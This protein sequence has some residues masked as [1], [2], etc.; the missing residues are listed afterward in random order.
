MSQITNPITKSPL[1]PINDNEEKINYLRL[2]RSKNLG[3]INFFRFLD[4]FGSATEAIAEIPKYL[5]AIKSK[6]EII[7]ASK[8]EAIREIENCNKIGA[9]LIYYTNE[10][11]PKLLREI[12]DPPPLLSALGNQELLQKS[13]IAIVGPRNPSLN[14]ILFA[15]KISSDLVK[16]GIVVVSGLARGVDG[17]AHEMAVDFATIAVIGCGINRVYPSEN[18]KLYQKIA[19]Q[20]L[21]ISEFAWNCEPLAVNFP[22]R[23]RI[24]SGLS[25]AVIIVEASLK[26]GTLIT[27]NYAA[28][29][30]RELFVVPGSPFDF[31][32]SGTNKLIKEGAKLIEN[33]DDIIEDLADLKMRFNI[34]DD[35]E[36]AANV[37]QEKINDETSANLNSINISKINYDDDITKIQSKIIA[38]LNYAPIFIEELMLE[39]QIPT[40]LVNSA[41]TALE[42]SDKIQTESG[43]IF[44]KKDP[45]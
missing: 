43:K 41:I 28:K 24:I 42:L 3:K 6:S 44:L 18:Q 20:G 5:L 1:I 35:E 22:Q 31:R 10:Q 11:Y 32:C 39:L 29:Q 17:A 34:G 8:N 12:D 40:K 19:N 15:K 16:H 14:A 36:L 33:I 13:S 7:I 27:A 26:S 45:Y 9:K 4:K 30:G 25:M 38:K 37:N 23:N 21:I 2:A